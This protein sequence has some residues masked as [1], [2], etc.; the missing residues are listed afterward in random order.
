MNRRGFL[1]GAIS[2]M[3]VAGVLKGR[4][5]EPESVILTDEPVQIYKDNY[6]AQQMESRRSAMQEDI[7]RM[8]YNISPMGR[9]EL[10]VTESDPGLHEWTED[11]LT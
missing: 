8:I 2:I 9:P 6:F 10:P 11:V 5:A 3:A 1:R 4:A 7:E